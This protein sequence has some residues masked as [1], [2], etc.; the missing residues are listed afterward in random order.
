M[1]RFAYC[2]GSFRLGL[3]GDQSQQQNGLSSQYNLN[4]VEYMDGSNGLWLVAGVTF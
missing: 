2:R 1:V 4:G 3:R